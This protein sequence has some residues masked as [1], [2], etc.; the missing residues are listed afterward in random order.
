M[1]LTLLFLLMSITAQAKECT[2]IPLTSAS[3]GKVVQ[4]PYSL[5][6]VVVI[7]SGK[8]TVRS[9]KGTTAS[10]RE[11]AE[12]IYKLINECKFPTP[13]PLGDVSKEK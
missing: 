5:I 13:K 4:I 12:T 2:T 6:S 11:S 3:T 10:V 8:T 1:K 9:E 7:E